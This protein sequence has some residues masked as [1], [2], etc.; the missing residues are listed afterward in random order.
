MNTEALDKILDKG[1]EIEK[2]ERVLVIFDN[3]RWEIAEEV[4][5]RCEEKK[6][7]TET[8]EISVPREH[9]F[10]PPKELITPF[11]SQDIVISITRSSITMSKA[12]RGARDKGTKIANLANIDLDLLYA[13]DV[14]YREIRERGKEPRKKINKA[15]KGRI[16]TEKGTDLSFELGKREVKLESGLCDSKGDVCTYPPGEM[17]FAPIEETVNGEIVVTEMRKKEKPFEVVY[18]VE[19]GKIQN[20]GDLKSHEVGE[21]GIGLNPKVELKGVFPHDLKKKGTGHVGVGAN[22]HL[23]GDIWN[24]RHYDI[25]IGR[26]T[27]ELDGE[28]VEF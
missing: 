21:I 17:C 6:A 9:F 18:S 1:L 26:C 14:D 19:D 24:E 28:V 22:F 4:A 12:A 7:R 13:C 3:E 16:T 2:G 8:R 20:P 23:G 15:K 11:K 10:E 27:L 5:E 25:G